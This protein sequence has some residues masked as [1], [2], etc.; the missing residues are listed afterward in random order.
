ML[1]LTFSR[2]ADQVSSHSLVRPAGM[3]GNLCWGPDLS[4]MEWARVEH[5]QILMFAWMIH[6]KPSVSHQILLAE[7]MLAQ[8]HLNQF[9]RFRMTGLKGETAH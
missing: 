1:P 5:L 8:S 4:N 6:N 2:P 7:L 3:Y 9:A